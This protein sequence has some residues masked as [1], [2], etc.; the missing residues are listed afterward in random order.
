LTARSK[1]GR[2]TV[3]SYNASTF[4][5]RDG[6]LQG[7]FAGARDVTERKRFEQE[8][9]ERNV[10]FERANQAKDRFL[11]SMS[12]EL[13]TPLNAIIGFT[14]TMLMGLAGPLNDEQEGQLRTVQAS[15]RHLLSL[16][17]DLLDLA[18]I[19]AGKLELA[20]EPVVVQDVIDEVVQTLRPL[21]S[22][23][24]L[25]FNVNVPPAKIG[26]RSDRRAL[27]QILLNLIN[28]AIKFTERGSITVEMGQHRDNGS[29]EVRIKIVDTGVGIREDDR[30]K[31]FGAFEQVHDVKTAREGTGLGLHLSMKLADL[32]GAR[33]ECES[34]FGKGSVFTVSLA[35]EV[36]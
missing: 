16:I 28:N 31:L 26:L 8:L 14:G 3:V 23:K 34:E 35:A 20:L 5:D 29:G 11:A 13:R 33:I 21:A 1:D 25:A 27:S 24:S 32:L 30:L 18:K 6:K 36:A 9:Q 12:H 7:V 4:F 10:E 15:A 22:Q 19:E 17:N 2:T